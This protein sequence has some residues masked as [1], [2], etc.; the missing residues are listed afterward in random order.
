MS[1]RPLEPGSVEKR[2]LFRLM[3]T[4]QF[5]KQRGELWQR[6]TD[7]RFL[8]ECFPGVASV[9][10]TSERSATLVVRPGFAFL[11]GNLEVSFEF[12]QSR[13]PVQA[14]AHVQIKGLGCSADATMGF[15]LTENETGSV[16]DWTVELTELRGLLKTVSQGL[17][18]GAAQ[19]VAGDTW[20]AFRARLSQA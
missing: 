4:E 9:Q 5:E 12:T 16:V 11:R 19:K 20:V 13:P 6:L 1:P 18:Q 17:L 8:S 2:G 14:L 15:E 10:Q 3:G 7:P